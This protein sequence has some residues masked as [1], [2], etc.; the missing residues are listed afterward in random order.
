MSSKKQHT[1]NYFNTLIEVAEDAACLVATTPPPKPGGKQTVA[2]L[3][4]EMIASAPY[5][6]TSDDVIFSVYATR[7][8]LTPEEQPAAR[9]AFFSKGQPCLRASPLT[10]RYGFGIHCDSEG[11]LALIDVQSETYQK[12]L[13]DPSVKKVKA[14][15][16]TRI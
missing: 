14:M 16:N 11:R 5:T 15:R 12:L 3:Q 4:Y 7:A 13:A 8:D 9:K 6:Y 2:S 10:K 1:T